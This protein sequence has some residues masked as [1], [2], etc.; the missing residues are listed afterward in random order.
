MKLLSDFKFEKIRMYI[1]KNNYYFSLFTFSKNN[2][3]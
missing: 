2:K 1:I 3:I